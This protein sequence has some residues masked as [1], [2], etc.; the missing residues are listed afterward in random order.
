MGIGNQ[1]RLRLAA[2]TRIHRQPYKHDSS[3]EAPVHSTLRIEAQICASPNDPCSDMPVAARPAPA[4][5]MLRE[6]MPPIQ[7]HF[8]FRRKR[9][10]KRYSPLSIDYHRE[11]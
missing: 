6:S 4:W 2:H 3:Q 11:Q 5:R 1:R 10:P 9:F 8:P 7:T